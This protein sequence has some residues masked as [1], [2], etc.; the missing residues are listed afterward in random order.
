[1]HICSGKQYWTAFHWG[2][3][4]CGFLPMSLW[5]AA[6]VGQG[7]NPISTHSLCSHKSK[8]FVFLF[9]LLLFF[10]SLRY[11]LLVATKHS[12]TLLS[13]SYKP[14]THD[15]L[16]S[17]SA[18]WPAAPLAACHALCQGLSGMWQLWH[19]HMF[20]SAGLTRSPQTLQEESSPKLASSFPTRHTSPS[21]LLPE[22]QAKG[23]GPTWDHCPH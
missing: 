2:C 22:S 6:L 18:A 5:W 1:M 4:S 16:H 13:K 17:R 8:G 7:S 10:F 20:T 21:S 19:G 14:P 11:I 23:S 12:R 9:L 15:V 3:L